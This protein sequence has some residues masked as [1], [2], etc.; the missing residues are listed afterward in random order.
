[1]TIKISDKTALDMASSP[2]GR[3][4]LHVIVCLRDHRVRRHLQGIAREITPVIT[5]VAAWLAHGR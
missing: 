3:M 2:F 4:A 1:M 5:L